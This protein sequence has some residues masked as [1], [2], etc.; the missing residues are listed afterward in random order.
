MLQHERIDHVGEPGAGSTQI[1]FD[2]TDAQ[3]LG[4]A[5]IADTV[6]RE[7]YM[8]RELDADAVQALRELVAI[9]DATLER[10]EDG[11]SGG[12][13]VMSVARLGVLIEA[14]REWSESRRTNGFARHH[15]ETDLD[16]ADEIL[17]DLA[18]LHVR[19]LHVALG[20]APPTSRLSCD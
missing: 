12:T 1:R 16:A 10:A 14:L 3:L 17:A 19:A 5:R 7:R 18:E 8:G 9:H 20:T 6:A 2:L 4:V 15:E 13:L 11:Y